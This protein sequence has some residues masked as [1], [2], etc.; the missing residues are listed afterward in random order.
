MRNVFCP[1]C[2]H[3]PCC[4]VLPSPSEASPA[5]QV[6]V[7]FPRA[8]LA[9]WVAQPLRG[10][11]RSP[12]H[13]GGEIMEYECPQCSGTGRALLFF[14]CQHC[15]G[16]GTLVGKPLPVDEVRQ[17][18]AAA[19]TLAAKRA[20]A[21]P[22]S[23]AA[24]ASPLEVAGSANGVRRERRSGRDRRVRQSDYRGIDR[25]TLPER[26]AQWRVSQP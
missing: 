19:M 14:G 8:I 5:T 13:K 7:G 11:G 26:R 10:S 17:R 23:A 1:I 9:P 20:S 18:F 24:Q 21:N 22:T 15:E 25:R 12:N 3:C 2:P 16:R 6:G 4:L